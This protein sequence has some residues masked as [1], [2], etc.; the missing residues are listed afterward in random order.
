MSTRWS[1]QVVDKIVCNTHSINNCDK[2]KS[3]DLH[4]TNT[5]LVLVYKI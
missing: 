1:K 5:R 3:I 4:K 2:K